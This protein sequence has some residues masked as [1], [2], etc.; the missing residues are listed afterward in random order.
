[1]EDIEKQIRRIEDLLKF[2]VQSEKYELELDLEMAKEK[3]SQIE[4]MRKTV[5]GGLVGLLFIII[6]LAA[7]YQENIDLAVGIVLSLSAITVFS[8]WIHLRNH[9]GAGDFFGTLIDARKKGIEN[10]EK[11]LENI[12]ID[13]VNSFKGQENSV[14][15]ILQFVLI[16]KHLNKIYMIPTWAKFTKTSLLNKEEKK[17]FE[18]KNDQ[19]KSQVQSLYD[20]YNELDKQYISKLLQDMANKIFE[21]Y[22]GK[23]QKKE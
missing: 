8:H 19:I 13:T 18:K 14:K 4:F 20:E 15:G 23:L 1:M 2:Y 5:V 7:V 17:E 22:E 3:L 21:S 12:I 6:G 11:V 9:R 10:F 16:L